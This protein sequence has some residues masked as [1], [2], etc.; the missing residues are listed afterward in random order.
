MAKKSKFL[1][2]SKNNVDTSLLN[3]LHEETGLSNYLLTLCIQRQLTTKETIEQ[4]LTPSIEQLHDPYL[5]YDMDKSV[6]RIREAIEKDEK[7]LIYGDYDADGITSTTVL[8]ETLEALGANVQYYLPNRFVDGYGPNLDVYKYMIEFEKINL[9]VTCDNG[10]SGHS[11]IEWSMAHGVDVIVTDHHELPEVL[12]NAFS[13]IHPRHPLGHYPF[14]DLAGVGVAFKLVCALLEDIPYEML[15]IVAIGTIADL[16]DVLGENRIL[17]S[18]GLDCLRNTSRIGL[19]HL[20]EKIG[21]PIDNA[22]ADTIAFGIAP[23][24]NA[25]GRLEEAKPGVQLLTTF[26]DEEA[27]DLVNYIESK[28]Q[29]RRKI[30]EQINKD[31]EKL[32]NESP[33]LPNFLLFAKENW[34][35]GVLGI[36]ASHVVEK[37]GK[38]TI[39]LNIDTETGLAKGSGRSVEDVNLY[40]VL[41]QCQEHIEQFGGHH[42]AA[43]M[44]ISVDQIEHLHEKLNQLTP[45][46]TQVVKYYDISLQPDE[47]NK[48]DIALVNEIEKLAPF[49]TNNHRPYF[50]L[51][52][53][54]LQNTKSLG[55]KQQHL[56]GSTSNLDF[57][58]F[59][60]GTYAN[61][62]KDNVTA[63]L[64]VTLNINEWNNIK[65]VQ[66]I[67]ADTQI[68]GTQYFDMRSSK[69]QQKHL[70]I[71]NATYICFNK[72]YLNYFKDK[73]QPTSQ[74]ILFDE[75]SCHAIENLVLFD[76]PTDLHQLDNIFDGRSFENIYIQCHISQSKYLTGLP[77]REQ[78][79]LIYKYIATKKS[80]HLRSHIDTL[81]RQLNLK[82]DLIILIFKVFYDAKFVT[83]QEG[84]VQ[85]L[86]QHKKA[87][88]E[89]TTTYIKQQ[90]LIKIEQQLIYSDFSKVCELLKSITK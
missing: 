29:E 90:S 19:I 64:Y 34:H 55:E 25:I 80:F 45:P 72:Q 32:L 76:C 44:T 8:V 67:V 30:T 81:S 1:W 36:V 11:A 65:R 46:N 71:R 63:N 53:T 7:I 50:L 79:A 43:G 38:P 48:V 54:I 73:I 13:I 61:F 51:E 15:D 74:M 47:L 70:E 21:M 82:Q 27:I 88:L 77:T 22:T 83:I 12:P 9:I 23:R 6:T 17:I 62:L 20:L 66:C 31:I 40:Q 85:F 33:V 60:G 89:S 78:F 41:S 26:D 18:F 59:N 75:L 2:K 52:H 49:G 57:I 28:N 35:P 4:F 86:E 69:I 10:V 87:N 68:E 3:T 42:M 24:L 37:T 5:L 56:K 84:V 58:Y 16:V 39:L 14:K